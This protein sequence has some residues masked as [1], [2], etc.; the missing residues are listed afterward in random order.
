MPVHYGSKALNFHTIGSS[1][2]TQ[3]PHAVG[4]A[5]A[6]KVSDESYHCLILF[7]LRNGACCFLGDSWR[8]N[9]A[10]TRPNPAA[11]PVTK[12]LAFNY[13]ALSEIQLALSV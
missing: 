9:N 11:S 3:L 1:L 5:Y 13:R 4:A 6:L 2:A 10:C 12:P 8:H 7:R